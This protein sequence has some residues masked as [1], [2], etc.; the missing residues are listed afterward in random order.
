MD[1]LNRTIIHFQD[2]T[3]RNQ[4]AV[5]SFLQKLSERGKIKKIST[6]YK[7]GDI[8]EFSIMFQT[9]ESVDNMSGYLN[10]INEDV[11]W[12]I[13]AFEDEIM[14]TPA[15]TLPS[16]RLHDDLLL[17]RCATEV[18]EDYVHPLFN[19]TLYELMKKRS[20]EEKL[21]PLHVEFYMQSKSLVD[22]LN[23]KD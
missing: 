17:L 3:S 2:P 15:L 14:M 5:I 18:W 12:S 23:K 9:W 4:T 10:Q 7:R 1:K 22:L 6:L 16:P 11:G 8:A 13:L 19:L 20:S 21:T